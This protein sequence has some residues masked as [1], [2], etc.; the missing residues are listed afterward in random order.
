MYNSVLFSIIAEF[1][2]EVLFEQINLLR[3]LDFRDQ[4]MPCH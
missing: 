3:C 2:L 1:S 4:T